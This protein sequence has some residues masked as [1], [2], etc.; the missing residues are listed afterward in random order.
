MF[1]H[2]SEE[3]TGHCAMSLPSNWRTASGLWTPLT[4]VKVLPSTLVKANLLTSCR[5]KWKG[6]G[7][8]GGV[9]LYVS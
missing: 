4:L 3:E 7:F 5:I 9:K 8:R 2:H 1:S 6:Q